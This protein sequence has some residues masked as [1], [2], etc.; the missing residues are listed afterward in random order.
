L[1]AEIHHAP[2][3]L[4]AARAEFAQNSMTKALKLPLEGSPLLHFSRLQEVVV[5]SPQV[6]HP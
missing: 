6:V 3:P 5:W 2:W 4:Q 1:R